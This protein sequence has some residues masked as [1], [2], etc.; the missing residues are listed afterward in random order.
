MRTALIRHVKND[1]HG[2]VNRAFIGG[3]APY[4]LLAL[5]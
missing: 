5:D 1:V 3:I 2:L 4:S